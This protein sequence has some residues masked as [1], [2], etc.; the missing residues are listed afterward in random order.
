M[1]HDNIDISKLMVHV[2]LLEDSRKNRG[3]RDARKPKRSDQ[4]NPR[5]CGNGNKFSVREHPRFKKGHQS[6]GKSN[7]QRSATPRK[8]KPELE[9]G[10]G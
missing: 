2:Q 5:N 3:L 7:F 8:G 1:L 4:T 10:N 9:K 6:L